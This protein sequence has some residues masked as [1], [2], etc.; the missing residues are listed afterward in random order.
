MVGCLMVVLILFVLV[1]GF[2]IGEWIGKALLA[3]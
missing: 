2:V 3:L 1:G